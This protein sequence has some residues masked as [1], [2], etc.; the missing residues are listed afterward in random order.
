VSS[1]RRK[2]ALIG[3]FLTLGLFLFVLLLLLMGS[4]DRLFT[5]FS[6]VEVEFENVQG[7]QEGDPVYILGK[8]VGRVVSLEFMPPPPGQRARLLVSLQIPEHCRPLLRADSKVKV[9]KSI[10]GN[11]SVLIQETDGGPLPEGDRLKGTPAAD[12]GVVTEKINEVLGDGEKLV[13]TIS[14]MVNQ[15]ENKGDLT[16]AVSDLSGLI[17]DVRLEVLPLRDQVRQ[18]LASLDAILQEN[19]LDVRHAVA[20]LKEATAAGKTFA[21]K[22]ATTP[23]M[24]DRS[25]AEVQKAGASLSGAIGENRAHIDSILQ[26]LRLASTSA[27]NLMAT[28]APGPTTWVPPNSIAPFAILPTC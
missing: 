11:I 8:K 7:L 26:D 4:M 1:K 27:S 10:T 3:G 18:I 9:D 13:A 14:R 25:L 19:R 12:F 21:E 16:N 6:V 24:I 17:K 15:V 20:N 28:I 22:L 23:E 5:S 2:E